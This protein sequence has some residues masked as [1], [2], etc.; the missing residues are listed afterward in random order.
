LALPLLAPAFS[1]LRVQG[2]V[3]VCSSSG[4]AHGVRVSGR[5]VVYCHTPARWLYQSER[6][7]R[8]R[9]AA[10]A[11]AARMLRAPLVRWDRSGARSAD[12]YLANSSVVA[13]R[14]AAVYGMDAD[15]LPPPPAV[16][17]DGPTRQ[18]G[19][20]EPGFVLCVA[21]LMP[22]K[23]V[24]AVVNA[25]RLLPHERLVVVGTGPD[26]SALRA[27]ATKNV[28]FLGSVGDDELRWLY[29]NCDLLVAAS[30]EDF[31]LTPLEAATFGKPSAVLRWG[32]FLDTVHE[33][34]TGTFFDAPDARLI[35][36][37]LGE[38]RRQTWND[39]AIRAHADTFSEE[40]FITR[41]RAI[42]DEAA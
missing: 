27:A 26:E 29:G 17:P 16:T 35:A 42:V 20:V 1:T 5:K 30:H 12:R 39:A 11:L 2:D 38:A 24:D 19:R 31:G 23:N 13:S 36:D 18:P 25:F 21:R 8:G 41:I 37:A 28:D 7:L 10:A 34:E 4:W 33:G 14:I 40:R 22:Y 3:V 9:G 32:G 15:V 6:Y